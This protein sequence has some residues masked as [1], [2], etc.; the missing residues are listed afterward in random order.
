MKGTAAEVKPLID[1]AEQPASRSAAPDV[2]VPMNNS[3]DQASVQLAMEK[4]EREDPL[5][6]A[7]K[8]AHRDQLMDEEEI[9]DYPLAPLMSHESFTSTTSHS[10][11]HR[12]AGSPSYSSSRSSFEEPFSPEADPN[13]HSLHPFPTDRAGIM[14]LLRQTQQRLHPDETDDGRMSTTPSRQGS[15][16]QNAS[17]PLTSVKEDQ[18]SEDMLLIVVDREEAAPTQ[19]QTRND[20]E[21]LSSQTVEGEAA[22]GYHRKHKHKHEHSQPAKE[23]MLEERQLNKGILSPSA[24]QGLRRSGEPYLGAVLAIAV[25]VVA[26]VLYTAGMFSSSDVKDGGAALGL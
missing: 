10:S 11:H 23:D 16:R 6:Q 14:E 1:F 25:A 4:G 19:T 7:E 12:H 2:S 15:H 9:E 22:T 24:Q 18:E 13:D 21:V 20:E 5:D 26:I 8:Q 3:V 17:T